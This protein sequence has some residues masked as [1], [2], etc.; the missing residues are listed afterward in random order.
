MKNIIFTI[1]FINIVTLAD[2]QNLSG[3]FTEHAGQ[4]L[5]LKGFN[6]YENYELAKTTLDSL[7]QFSLQYPKAYKG[8]GVLQFQDKNNLVLLLTEPDI[9]LQGTH[10]K[11]RDNLQYINSPNNIDF[12][13]FATHYQQEKQAYKAWRY[14]QRKYSA[15]KAL[16]PHK[17]VLKII[18]TETQR[19]EERQKK[20]GQA[21][22]KEVICV[23]TSPGVN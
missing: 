13:S 23:G 12:A 4:T 15:D 18:R 22:K 11:E 1:L 8:V 21:L 5:V 3:Q 16:L 20:G 14:L 2:A 6:Y 19:I 9:K 10:I 17:K 7:G